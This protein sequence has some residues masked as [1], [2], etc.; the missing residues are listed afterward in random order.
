METFS[1]ALIRPEDTLLKAWAAS[2][3]LVTRQR[4]AW[5]GTTSRQYRGPVSLNASLGEAKEVAERWRKQGSQFS[6][7]EVPGLVLEGRFR[8]AIVEFHSEN[9]FSSW[10]PTAKCPIGAGESLSRVCEVLEIGVWWRP[11]PDRNSMVRGLL[12]DRDEPAPI[13]PGQTFRTW[14][15]AFYGADFSIHWVENRGRHRA[16]GTVEVARRLNE[17]R[18]EDP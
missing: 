4:N 6:I 14:S 11:R 12:A 15:S 7:Q 9:S 16:N 10:D 17:L 13:T 5:W 18:R 2:F 1:R 3:F 8:I